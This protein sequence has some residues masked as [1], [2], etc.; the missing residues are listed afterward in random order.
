MASCDIII[1]VW[2]QLEATRK[3]LESVEKNTSYPYRVILVDNG[4]EKDVKAYL[5]RFAAV[6]HGRVT[7]I[8][9]EENTGYIKAVNQA[10]KYANADH[11]CVMNNDT[12]VCSG[13]LEEMARVM[14]S[15]A[16]IGIVNPSSNTSGQLPCIW[17]NIADYANS[18]KKYAGQTQ[19]L[20]NCRGFC[21]LIRPELFKKIGYFDESYGPGYFEEADFSRK[22]ISA[23]Y[24]IVRAKASYVF[25]TESLSFKKLGNASEIFDVNKMLFEKRWGRS[26]KIGFAVFDDRDDGMG[27]LALELARRGHQSWIFLKRGVNWPVDVDHFDLRRVDISG[28]ASGIHLLYQLT[29]RRK[30]K[31]MDVMIVSDGILRRV[32]LSTKKLHGVEVEEY[33]RYREECRLC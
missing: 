15:D 30:K 5:E 19:E 12:D 28:W 9:N 6:S 10:L 22:A 26:L 32:L 20:F 1:P 11:V 16:G 8:S 4:S 7:L 29:K 17:Q 14:D 33:S 21:M 27:A 3:C 2:N 18:L 25:H 23:G 13:W 24:R 31:G